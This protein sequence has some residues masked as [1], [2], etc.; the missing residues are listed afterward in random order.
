ME[1]YSDLSKVDK[2]ARA[3]GEV[4]GL[5]DEIGSGIKKLMGNQ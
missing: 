5:K 3:Q 1:N 4:E 2:V